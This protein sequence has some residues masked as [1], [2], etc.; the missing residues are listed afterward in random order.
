MSLELLTG[1][2]LQMLLHWEDRNSMAHSLESRVPFLDYR[3]VE[4]VTGLPDHY[5]IRNGVTK[6]VMREGMKDLVPAPVLQRRD[7][8]GFVTAEEVWARENGGQVFRGR[9]AEAVAASK[10]IL[11]SNALTYFEHSL[12]G[13]AAYD[14]AVWRMICLGTWMR[15]FNATV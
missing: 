6:T 1:A 4:F 7:K 13:Q 15:L 14:S 11:P 9:L 5:K 3:L 8:M 10:G 12:A 2:H